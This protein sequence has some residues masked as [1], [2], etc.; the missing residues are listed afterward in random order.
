MPGTLQFSVIVPLY[1]K[2]PVVESTLRSILVDQKHVGE[3]IVVDDGSTDDGAAIVEAIADPRV[4]LIR[5]KNG[6][7]SSARNIGL[8][9]ASFDWIA[10]LD[11]DDLW[12]SDYLS[13]L[14]S[15]SLSFPDC[16]M[17]ATSFVRSDESGRETS[18]EGNWPIADGTSARIEDYYGLMA[19]GHLCFTGSI[20]VRRSLIADHGLRFPE[21]EF[22]GEDLDF[23]TRSAELTAVALCNRPLVIYRD[24]TQVERLTDRR[25][26]RLVPPFVERLDARWRAGTL[27]VVKQEGAALYLRSLYEH[28]AI[29]GVREGRRREALEVIFHPLLRKSPVRWLGLIAFW[30]LPVRIGGRLLDRRRANA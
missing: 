23:F 8:G 14:E 3:V 22:L 27:P 5:R 7:V 24:S 9:V 15:L 18:P 12:L 25:L 4:R 10:F 1:N 29:I 16:A 17:L 30:A 11:A 20:A 2:A 21:G 28:I 19:G 6:G 26:P 13:T